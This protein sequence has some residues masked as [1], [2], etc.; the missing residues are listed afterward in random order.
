M[1]N[2]WPISRVYSVTGITLYALDFLRHLLYIKGSFAGKAFPESAMMKWALSFYQHLIYGLYEIL[3]KEIAKKFSQKFPF[4]RHRLIG[5]AGAGLSV[6]G[7]GCKITGFPQQKAGAPAAL[8]DS[9]VVR[10][11]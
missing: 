11:Q 1:T 5:S 10:P 2:G 8:Q 3:L 4:R 9:H 7:S 6:R